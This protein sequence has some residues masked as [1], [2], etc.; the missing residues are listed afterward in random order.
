MSDPESTLLARVAACEKRQQ[1][2]DRAAPTNCCDVLNVLLVVV[3]VLCVLFMAAGG[4][5]AFVTTPV[6]RHAL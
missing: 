4:K 6:D 3:G 1:D 5:V 2:L